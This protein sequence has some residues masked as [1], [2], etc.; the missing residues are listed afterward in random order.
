M[1][2]DERGIVRDPVARDR[3]LYSTLRYR[4]SASANIAIQSNL[5][6]SAGATRSELAQFQR[7]LL[8]STVAIARYM[9]QSMAWVE[10]LTLDRM[11][12]YSEVLSEILIEERG[13]EPET[14][15]GFVFNGDE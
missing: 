1:T 13:G 3:L 2:H 12:A 6:F 9:R 15:S 11:N 7:S 8:K 4:S 5:T 10:E 14:R